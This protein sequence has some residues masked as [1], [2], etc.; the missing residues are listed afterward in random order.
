[1]TITLL[2]LRYSPNL[3]LHVVFPS[4]YHIAEHVPFQVMDS[5]AHFLTW[6]KIQMSHRMLIPPSRAAPPPPPMGLPCPHFRTVNVSFLRY[7]CISKFKNCTI[8][9]AE[10]CSKCLQRIYSVI[11]ILKHALQVRTEFI[12]RSQYG[13]TWCRVVW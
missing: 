5:W 8:L 4:S 7:N 11:W 3:P 13:G 6:T 9:T 10:L 2:K 1:M 12:W